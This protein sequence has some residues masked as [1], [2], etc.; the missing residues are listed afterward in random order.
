MESDIKLHTH[1]TA[2]ANRRGNNIMATL[3]SGDQ[4]LG[5]TTISPNQNSKNLCNHHNHN[6]MQSEHP[7]ELNV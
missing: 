3:L 7:L 5:K 4:Q 6:Y 1:N 2:A